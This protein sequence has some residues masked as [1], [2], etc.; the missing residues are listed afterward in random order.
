MNVSSAVSIVCVACVV[1]SGS[2]TAMPQAPRPRDLPAIGQDV[3]ASLAPTESHEWQLPLAMSE[4]VQLT[5]EPLA[6]A[7]TDEWPSI[8]VVN[9]N[10]NVVYNTLEPSVTAGIDHW[11]GAWCRSSPTIRESTACELSRGHRPCSYRVRLEQRR[12]AVAEDRSA[13]SCASAL[14]RRHAGFQRGLS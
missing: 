14:A 6:P 2:L 5:V 4:F 13:D 3:E 1:L 11:A 12:A 10:G 7:E 8:A 9:A